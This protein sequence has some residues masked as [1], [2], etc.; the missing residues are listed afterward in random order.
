MIRFRALVA[1]L[2]LAAAVSTAP[3]ASAEPA[4][5][6]GPIVVA[7]ADDVP[8]FLR[9]FQ[10]REPQRRGPSVVVQPPPAPAAP[11][12]LRNPAKRSGGSTARVVAPPAPP[13]PDK[14]ADARIVA[15]VGDSLAAN[16]AKGLD[17]A[18]ADTPEL[19][20][21]DESAGSSGLVRDDFKDWPQDLAALMAPPPAPPAVAAEAPPA[22]DAARRPDAVVVLMGMN[23]RQ[24]IR[25]GETALEF[26]E[27]AWE[28]AYR[29]RI[30]AVVAAGTSGG[31]PLYWVGLVPVG[32]R[33]LT[34]DFAYLDE[35]IRQEVEAAGSTY[36]DVWNA[37]ADDIG[38]FAASGPDL[39]GQVRRL[40]LADGIHFTTSGQ[41]KLAFYAEQELR[42]W[43]G[44]AAAPLPEAPGTVE[45]LVMSL[46][47]PTAGPDEA[48]AGAVPGPA[49]R[50]G[51]ALYR[52]MV[53][54][55][56]LEPVPGRID[57]ARR[58]TN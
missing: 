29:A 50:E 20:I 24:T 33:G 45:G 43:L 57:D 18:F 30:R 46:N 40:R 52:L 11:R 39:A 36:V 17:V 31:A 47:D 56:P 9:L 48:L 2:V 12:A 19:R 55:L 34:A 7:Q 38:D 5:P 10:R 41:R 35:M 26:R 54:G 58:A 15:V 27:A 28:T 1:G 32:N 22:G 42:A 16:L 21:A 51:T 4:R 49:P 37:F 25:I 13:P 3:M 8:F 44:G 23:D 53:E 6:A 14:N